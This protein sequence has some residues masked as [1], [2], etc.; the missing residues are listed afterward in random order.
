MAGREAARLQDPAVNLSIGQ[1]YVLA[2]ADDE[3]IDGDLIR[4]LA[5]Y[6]Q[7][8]GGLRKW[9]DAVRDNGDPLMFIEA[10]PNAQ[11]REFIEEALMYSWRYA[12]AM[13]LPA[14]SLDALARGHYPRLIRAGGA[15]ASTDDGACARR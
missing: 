4:L 2:L 3:A 15:A 11:T 6:G 14:T 1:Q 13:R 8:Q 12:T 5:G 9:V 10:I 7:G